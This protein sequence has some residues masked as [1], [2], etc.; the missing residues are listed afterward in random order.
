MK[1]KCKGCWWWKRNRG[2]T[3]GVCYLKSTRTPEG[4]DYHIMWEDGSC[5]VYTNRRK[6]NK[7]ITLSAWLKDLEL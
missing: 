5:D 1:G 7:E 6:K 3:A 2:E 4:P